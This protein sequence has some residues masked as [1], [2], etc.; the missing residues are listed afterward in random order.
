MQNVINIDYLV[1][2]VYTIGHIQIKKML[3]LQSHDDV[4]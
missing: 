2:S 4:F 1:I 3:L